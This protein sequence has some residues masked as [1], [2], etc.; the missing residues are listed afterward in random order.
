MTVGSGRVM[1]GARRVAAPLSPSP[2]RGS[3]IS[4]EQLRIRAQN[5]KLLVDRLG[6][7]PTLFRGD[8]VDH[9][10]LAP[11]DTLLLKGQL[12]LLR[13]E[14]PAGGAARSA[15]SPPRFLAPSA[16]PTSSVCWARA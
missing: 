16:R 11:G 7:C 1:F 2:L 3:G 12:L 14:R 8:K 9:C 10:V 13:V 5:G 6:R 15:T 4:R